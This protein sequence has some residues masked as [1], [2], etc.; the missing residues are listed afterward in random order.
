MHKVLGFLSVLIL[1][2]ACAY[3][4][5]D[6]SSSTSLVENT[7]TTYTAT[8]TSITITSGS[9]SIP[10][11]SYVPIS[12][13]NNDG[14]NDENLDNEEDKKDEVPL[15]I[16]I[17]P[18]LGVLG[19]ILII[20]AVPLAILG[21]TSRWTGV[22]I[23]V[24]YG[25]MIALM[26]ILLSTVVLPKLH[27]INPTRASKALEGEILV[28]CAILGIIAA[29]ASWWFQKYVAYAV[30]GFAGMTLAWWIQC[31]HDGGVIHSMAGKWIFYIGLGTVC[32]ILSNFLPSYNT[33]GL[34]CC[35]FSSKSN[36]TSPA[37]VYLPYW[38]VGIH[39]RHRLFR[40]EWLER[41]LRLQLRI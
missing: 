41:V 19:A 37:R 38:F 22:C 18:A 21:S 14:N 9:S 26:C 12:N 11:Q 4:Q 25:S 34:R 13:D 5:D 28:G 24:A 31:L 15:T 29:V 2:I 32:L 16:K 7:S 35:L 20:T 8:A 10:T 23:P 17:T 40:Q 3:G 1:L 36:A 39:N 6:K 33:L 30:C 27:S